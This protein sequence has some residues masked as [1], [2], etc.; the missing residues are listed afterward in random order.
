MISP[1]EVRMYIPYAPEDSCKTISRFIKSLY[2]RR[3]SSMEISDYEREVI[4]ILERISNNYNPKLGHLVRY[5]KNTLSL[6]LKDYISR[7]YIPTISLTE[8]TLI[9]NLVKDI[10]D[11]WNWEEYSDGTIQ[12]VYNVMSG[13]GSK[14][15]RGIVS[16]LFNT[17]LK[18]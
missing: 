6:K 9:D 1:E 14:K 13:K 11:S 5:A 10:S 15:D 18:E 7:N 8:D 2:I 3:Y 4:S 16:E 12:A 17:E